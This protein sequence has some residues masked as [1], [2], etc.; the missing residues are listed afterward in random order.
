MVTC[1]LNQS[2]KIW[3]QEYYPTVQPNRSSKQDETYDS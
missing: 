3:V 1:C 2:G